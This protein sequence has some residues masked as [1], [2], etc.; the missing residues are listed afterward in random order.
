MGI[1][2]KLKLEKGSVTILYLILV[3]PLLVGM[4]AYFKV[5]D[6]TSMVTQFLTLLSALFVMSEVGIVSLLKKGRRKDYLNIA[7]GIIS[8]IAVISVLWTLVA[9]APIAILAPYQ[10]ILNLLLIL[11]VFI[12]AFR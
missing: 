6:L 8:V 4:L 10:G 12:T 1:L 9:G 5:F 2:P 11:Y 7:G 3:V